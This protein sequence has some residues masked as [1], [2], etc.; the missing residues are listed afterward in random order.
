MIRDPRRFWWSFGFASG[1]LFV[2]LCV[3]GLVLVLVHS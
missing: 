3:I 1:V 2:S